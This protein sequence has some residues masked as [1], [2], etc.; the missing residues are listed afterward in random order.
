[1]KPGILI[2]VLRHLALIAFTWF[3]S[4]PFIAMLGTA[5]RKPGT[6]RAYVNLI[7]HSLK[8]IT[9]HNIAAVVVRP[10]F[11]IC[12][13]NSFFVTALVVMSCILLS[14]TTAFAISR[15]KG[16]FLSAYTVMLLMLQMFPSMLLLFPLYLIFHNLRLTNTLWAL[17][18]SYIAN[19]LSFSILMMKV[20]FDTIPK[21]LE[22][23]AMVDGCT[24]FQAFR[25]IVVPMTLP[26]IATVGIFNFIYSWNE[27]TFAS[28]FIRSEHL[29]T[30]PIGFVQGLGS[31]NA[32]G[33]ASCSI[34]TIPSILFLL[35]A[36]KY[37]IEGLT[38][39]SVKG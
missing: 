39:G 35:F 36:Q 23:A 13:S 20:F 34:A 11:I 3:I 27:Y 25:R 22:Q 12:L 21:E 38:M 10:R 18:I 28:V 24:R 7:P 2:K 17:I 26:G 4:L 16:W 19:T 1:M 5:I 31:G 30:M 15:F 29:F 8:E 37:F 6:L 32:M 33:M 9:F 14:I